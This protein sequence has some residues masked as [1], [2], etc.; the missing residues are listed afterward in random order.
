MPWA[1][2]IRRS[3]RPTAS[4]RKQEMLTAAVAAALQHV[5]E[6]FEV[7]IDK[8]VRMVER[9]ANAGLGGGHGNSCTQFART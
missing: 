5:G 8:G 6:A 4:K 3:R 9:I 2:L 7:S 1:K